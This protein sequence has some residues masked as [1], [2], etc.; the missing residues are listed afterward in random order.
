MFSSP[1]PTLSQVEEQQNTW[2]VSY[3]TYQQRYKK[4]KN[5]QADFWQTQQLW[6]ER[7]RIYQDMRDDLKREAETLKLRR[8]M[9]RSPTW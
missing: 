2:R 1:I 4:F 8:F 7:H 6:H 3:M 9:Q 5:Q